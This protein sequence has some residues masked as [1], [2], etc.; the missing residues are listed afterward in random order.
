MVNI[1][2]LYVLVGK[3]DLALLPEYISGSL[4]YPGLLTPAFVTN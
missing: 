3:G 1:T 2:E 4:V